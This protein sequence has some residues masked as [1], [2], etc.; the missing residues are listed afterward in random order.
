MGHSNSNDEMLAIVLNKAVQ[1]PGM[2]V[3]RE[4][5][6]RKQFKSE[7]HEMITAIVEKG[8]IEANFSRDKLRIKARRIFLDRTLTSAGLSF[9]AGLPGGFAAGITIPADTLQ[10]FTMALRAAQ[11]VA[12]LYGEDDFWNGEISDDEQVTGQLILYCGVMF[13][14]SGASSAVRVV[15]SQLAKAALKQLPQRALTKGVIYPMVKSVAKLLTVQM[16]KGIFAKGVSKAIPVV[17]GIV[18]GSITLVT[19]RPMGLRLINVLDH[20]HFAYSDEQLENDLSILN[21]VGRSSSASGRDIPDVVVG[22]IV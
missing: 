6:L 7:S 10:F 2:K 1:M 4:A 14:A 5:F 22:E 21:N 12:Y 19:M 20:S 18:S 15:S 8:P 11:E 3:D 9:A 13:G 16:T 17:G